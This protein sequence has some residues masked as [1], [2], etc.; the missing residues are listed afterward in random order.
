MAQIFV[1]TSAWYAIYDKRDQRHD[2]ASKFLRETSD[3]LISSN[4]IFAETLSLMT[5]RLGKTLALN[6]GQRIRASA[7]VRL[8]H[9][10]G[11]LEERAWGYFERYHDKPWD[12]IDCSSFALMD[13]LELS[14]AF[15]F[16]A[17]FTQ[18]GFQISP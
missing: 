4:L 11:A 6:F 14:R 8:L 3:L 1:D 9:L 18:K 15:T 5:K 12:F 17:H 13:S 7:K 10:D 16:D 2:Q